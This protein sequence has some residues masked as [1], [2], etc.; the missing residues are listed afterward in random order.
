MTNRFALDRFCSAVRRRGALA[1]CLALCTLGLGLSATADDHKASIITIDA[2]GAGTAP[3]QG[4][5]ANVV[6]P[7]G[8]VA[9]WYLDA[10]YTYYSFLRTPNGKI[11]TFSPPGRRL[12]NL[13]RVR[14]L[15][16]QPGGRDHRGLC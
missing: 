2:P 10:N 16:H 3:G 1:L 11:I 14:R 5:Q 8:T 12:R 4:T 9:G 15:E 13:P 6:N 7:E